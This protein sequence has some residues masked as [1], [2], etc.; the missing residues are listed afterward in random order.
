MPQVIFQYYGPLRIDHRNGDGLDNRRINLRKAT[1]QENSFNKGPNKNNCTGY[2]GV[3]PFGIGRFRAQ[4]MFNKK[5][6]F[7]GCF[8]VAE[9]AAR[10]YDKKAVELMG[11]FAWTNFEVG[12]ENANKLAPRYRTT[13]IR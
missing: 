1:H 10:A 13:T 8:D 2:K 7:L 6:V 11:E 4:I 5:Q 12:P 3:A 9:E